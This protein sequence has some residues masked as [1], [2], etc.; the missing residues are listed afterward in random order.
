MRD[1]INA[2]IVPR[3]DAVIRV[4]NHGRTYL[5]PLEEI[6]QSNREEDSG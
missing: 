5:C 1:P 3:M 4:D 2:A 6:R